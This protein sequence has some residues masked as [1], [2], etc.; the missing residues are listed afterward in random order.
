MTIFRLLKTTPYLYPFCTA[1]SQRGSTAMT[2]N[3][4]NSILGT[5]DTTGH[6]EREADVIFTA[7]FIG[8]TV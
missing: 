6:A 8:T 7:A 4:E 5:E 1:Y 2:L 3:T